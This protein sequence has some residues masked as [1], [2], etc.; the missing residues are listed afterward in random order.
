[1]EKIKHLPTFHWEQDAS[2]LAANP[3]DFQ[4]REPNSNNTI[5]ETTSIFG[6]LL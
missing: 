2:G 4:V 1:M 5:G 6:E 3:F